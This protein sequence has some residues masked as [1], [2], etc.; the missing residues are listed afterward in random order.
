M[1]KFALECAQVVRVLT[2]PIKEMCETTGEITDLVF[3]FA[4]WERGTN[5]PLGTECTVSGAG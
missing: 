4:T 2:E 1:C 5:L 3:R